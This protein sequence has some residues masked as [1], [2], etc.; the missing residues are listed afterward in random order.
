[1]YELIN[2]SRKV[3]NVDTEEYKAFI[4]QFHEEIDL[5]INQLDA[6]PEEDYFN[7]SEDTII[8][9]KKCHHAIEHGLELCPQ[10][11]KNYKRKTFSTCFNCLPIEIKTQL[12]EKK[13]LDAKIDVEHALHDAEVHSGYGG[14]FLKYYEQVEKI[15][16]KDISF[17]EKLKEIEKL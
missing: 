7:L 8:L 17:I 14:E 11:K 2:G 1:M 3:R 13:E 9:C 10:C 16:K 5:G 6:P 4:K 15:T 12:I